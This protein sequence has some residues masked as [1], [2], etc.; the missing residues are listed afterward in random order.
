MGLPTTHTDTRSPERTD[1]SP[2][3]DP[4]GYRGVALFTIT[5]GRVCAEF[6]QAVRSLLLHDAAGQ[7]HIRYDLTRQ[8]IGISVVRNA[9]VDAF[10]HDTDAEWMLCLDDDT[11]PAMDTV[12][13]LMQHAKESGSLF[14]NGLYLTTIEEGLV[15]CAWGM[16]DAPLTQTQLLA[17]LEA[18]NYVFEVLKVGAG[19]ALMH[20]D[21]L[22]KMHANNPGDPWFGEPIIDGVRQGEDFAFCYRARDVGIPPMLDIEVNVGHVKTIIW[23]K[24]MLGN[25]QV[26]VD[27]HSRRDTA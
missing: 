10:L 23:S 22:L 16:D 5:S 25:V 24:A 11:V 13:I 9:A 6:S 1:D 7:Q 14:L 20:R 15:A 2:V 8:G 18:E 26:T 19:C 3:P 4:S 27:D 21:L 12:D 17:E